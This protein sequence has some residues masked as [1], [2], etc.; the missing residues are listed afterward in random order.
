MNYG[1]SQNDYINLYLQDPSL[2]TPLPPDMYRETLV[3]L[4]LVQGD[5]SVQTSLIFDSPETDK[6]GE[7]AVWISWMFVRRGEDN[8]SDEVGLTKYTS[9]IYGSSSPFIYTILTKFADYFDMDTIFLVF[10]SMLACS[11]FWIFGWIGIV[12]IS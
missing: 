12:L 10:Y 7:N 11:F 4:T 6:I 5:Q 2:L 1:I 9:Q 3:E 8:G